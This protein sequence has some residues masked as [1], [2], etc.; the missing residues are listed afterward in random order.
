MK[1]IAIVLLGAVIVVLAGLCVIMCMD[2]MC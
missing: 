1:Y 2:I